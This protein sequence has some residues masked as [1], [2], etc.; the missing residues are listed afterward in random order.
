MAFN[1]A[2]G[3]VRNPA[4]RFAKFT[5]G[6]CQLPAGLRQPF[7]EDVRDSRH[8]WTPYIR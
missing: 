7:S 2:D 5:L 3:F 6:H 8:E 4:D 1:P